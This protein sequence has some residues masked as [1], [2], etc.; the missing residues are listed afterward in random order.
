MPRLRIKQ[1]GDKIA[2]GGLF[3]GGGPERRKLQPGEVIDIPEDFESGQYGGKGLFDAMYASG[4]VEMT[5][6]AATR[7]VDYLDARE[8]KFS[9]PTFKSRGADEDIEV[10]KARVAVTTRLA[11]TP[12]AQPSADSPANGEQSEPSD[13]SSPAAVETKPTTNRRAQRRAATQAAV[14]DSEVST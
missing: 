12:E 7:P 13:D 14:S 9:S 3:M 11:Q 6:D 8:A 5:P 2:T 10:E 1:L 4:L